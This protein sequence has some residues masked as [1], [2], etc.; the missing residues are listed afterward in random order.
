MITVNKRLACKPHEKIS[1]NTTQVNRG[2]ALPEEKSKLFIVEVLFD[3][4]DRDGKYSVQKGTK[5]YLNYDAFRHDFNRQI[6]THDDGTK[7]ILV[8]EDLIVAV[9][10]PPAA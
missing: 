10:P 4:F 1:M 2:L 9:S 7:F 8:P 6:Y 3:H 5:L